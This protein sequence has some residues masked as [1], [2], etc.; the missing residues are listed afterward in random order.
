MEFKCKGFFVNGGHIEFGPDGMLYIGVGEGVEKGL[1][2]NKE[3]VFGSILRIDVSQGNPYAIPSDN[4]WISETTPE[5]WAYGLRNPY[6][7]TFDPNTGQLI[8]SDVGDLLKEEINVV[9]KGQNYGWPDYEGSIKS[10]QANL[11]PDEVIPPLAE[12]D[13]QKGFGSAIVGSYVYRG[14]SYPALRGKLIIA[15]WS[16]DMFYRNEISPG[17]LNKLIIDNLEDFAKPER[18]IEIVDGKEE[19]QP[20][21]YTNSLAV[22]EDGELYMIGQQGI[23]LKGSGSVFKLL[24]RHQAAA[25]SL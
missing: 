24:F 23:G 16:G 2:Q 25:R 13:H 20:K 7:F 1:A 18:D 10:D 15:D 8:C 6:R 17:P 5:I 4:P 3:N 9:E 19:I 12:Y 22:D 21:Y 11:K 14:R